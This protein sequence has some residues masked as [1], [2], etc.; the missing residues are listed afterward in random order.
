MILLVRTV[1]ECA[2]RFWHV[3]SRFAGRC[4]PPTTPAA[5]ES[6]LNL[7]YFKPLVD[8]IDGTS[9]NVLVT[10][11]AGTGK[12]TFLRYF[13]ANTSKRV[14]VLAP[15]GLAALNVGGQTVHSFFKLKPGLIEPSDITL[16]PVRAHLYRSLDA[17]IIDEVSMVRVDVLNAVDLSLQHHRG[18]KLPFGGVQLV[19]IGDLFQLAPVVPN[20]LFEYFKHRYGGPYFFDVPAFK[21]GDFQLTCHE[22]TEVMRQQDASLVELLDRVRIGEPT[23]EDLI[24][25][26][27]RHVEVTGPPPA[28]AVVLTTT[29]KD[30]SRINRGALDKLPSRERLYDAVLTGSLKEAYERVVSQWRGD[31]ESL[32]DE[33]ERKFPTSVE[34]RLK[35]GAK[36]IMVKNDALRRWVNGSLGTLLAAEDDR[37]FVV[38]NS[39]RME[40][41]REKWDETEYTIDRAQKKI[42]STTRGSFI[43]FPVRL[44]WAL[45]IH[46]AQGQSLSHVCVDIG[47]GAFA[48]GQTYVAL[49]RCRTFDGLF[50][51]REIRRR[52]IF[53]DPRILAF[54]E[55]LLYTHDSSER[56]AE[57]IPRAGI[58]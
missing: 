48:A 22:L 9:R 30:A 33:L 57:P 28:E 11:R 36:I 32:E 49:S 16:N 56:G 50:L 18:N 54:S 53:T 13:V 47:R 19:L 35:P 34:L 17:V 25:L 42:T 45:T 46:K 39:Q 6:A 8:L 40:V 10:G 58:Q 26:H 15:T 38:I 29:N 24:H 21:R 23:D 55:R 4:C 41:R 2:R 3:I 27:G 52:D 51:Q 37:L 1:L 5:S 7:E 14:V 20:D 31:P 12:S 44:A 43:Q